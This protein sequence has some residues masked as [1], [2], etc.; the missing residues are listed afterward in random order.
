MTELISREEVIK[1][2][3]KLWKEKDSFS[4]DDIVNEI[5][6]VPTVLAVVEGTSATVYLIKKEVKE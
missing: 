1:A 5:I 6:C 3:D 4:L 2:M